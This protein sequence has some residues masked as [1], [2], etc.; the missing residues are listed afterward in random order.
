MPLPEK[1]VF[2]CTNTRPDADP[3]GCCLTRAGGTIR[4]L[5]KRLIA[6]RGL[7]GKVR[8]NSTDCLGQCEHGAV[9]VVYPDGTWYRG[10]RPEDVVQIVES[11]LVRGTPVEPLLLGAPAKENKC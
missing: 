2:V 11:H 4:D 3:R 9:V 1:H 7:K 5:F 8:I 6:E 10:V